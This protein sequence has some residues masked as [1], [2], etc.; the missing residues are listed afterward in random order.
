[1]KN[2]I[3][4]LGIAL[5]SFASFRSDGQ[6]KNKFIKVENGQFIRDGKPYYYIGTNYWYGAILGSPGKEGNRKRLLEE[7]D[8]MKANGI[9]NLC[10]FAE[11]FYNM[12]RTAKG[13]LAVNYPSLQP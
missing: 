7:L 12:L 2:L 9:D 13:R 6:S 8:L 5:L 4:I 11:V 3:F 1:M 10:V